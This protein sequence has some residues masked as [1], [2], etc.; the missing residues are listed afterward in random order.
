MLKD[1]NA[2]SGQL[3]EKIK[4]LQ[5]DK[6]GLEKQLKD[7]QSQVSISQFTISMLHA[8]SVL[9]QKFNHD[10]YSQQLEQL[11]RE[12]QRFKDERDDLEKQLN[13]LL[14]SNNDSNTVIKEL[15]EKN[16]E[17][18]TQLFDNRRELQEIE[19]EFKK[20]QTLEQQFSVKMKEMQEK[21]GK[22]QGELREA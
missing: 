8:R 12:K 6:E 11:H 15:R 18:E 17:L 20:L 14:N 13:D 9:H 3:L 1:S 4:Q 7:A 10:F 22:A 16:K 19:R 5:S 21:L 2:S